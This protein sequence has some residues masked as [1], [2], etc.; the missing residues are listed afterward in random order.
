M[1]RLF[2][3]S[4]AGLAVAAASLAA[5]NANANPSATW[6]SHLLTHREMPVVGNGA[7]GYPIRL[8]LPEPTPV[9]LAST[10]SAEVSEEVPGTD[11]NLET[12]AEPTAVAPDGQQRGK[13]ALGPGIM[14]AFDFD[15]AQFGN[16]GALDEAGQIRTSKPVILAGNRLGAINLSVGKGASVSVDRQA[17]ATLVA[18]KSPALSDRLS[19]L[20]GDQVTLDSLR[21]REVAVRYDALTDAIVIDTNS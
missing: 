13:P 17:L 7:G 14:L 11:Q 8:E 16:G 6:G 12:E 18:D 4:L 20:E 15:I 3:T 10:T 9:A 19:R 1:V 2:A 21:S 5:W